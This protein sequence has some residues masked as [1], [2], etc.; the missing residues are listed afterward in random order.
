MCKVQ[1]HIAHQ[2]GTSR[3]QVECDGGSEAVA[4]RQYKDLQHH[5]ISCNI[6]QH[7]MSG[8][9]EWS[10]WKAQWSSGRHSGVAVQLEDVAEQQ[11]ASGVARRCS[12]TVED[13]V[14]QQMPR[15]MPCM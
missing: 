7:C 9:R 5:A 2:H 14:V 15:G 10:S 12:S 11:K 13:A 6:V 8:L 3:K 1:H 4:G